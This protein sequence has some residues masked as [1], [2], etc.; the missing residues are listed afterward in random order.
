VTITAVN[1][2]P[3][4]TPPAAYTALA[5]VNKSVTAAAGLHDASS[6]TDP[7]GT[8][9]TVTAN[10]VSSANA[11]ASSVSNNVVIAADGSS[12][13]DPPTGF[14]GAD[15]FTY[16]VCDNGSPAP[17]QCVNATAT[18]NVQGNDGT[19]N[20]TAPVLWFIDKN[21]ATA[22]TT[23]GCGRKSNPFTTIASFQ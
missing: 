2:P 23:A 22:C 18:V 16:Q 7:D 3:S 17:N 4:V 11:A 13:Y 19:T 9:F 14:V 8:A 6:V 20:A 1:D 15:T 10:T 21:A 12:T 5:N